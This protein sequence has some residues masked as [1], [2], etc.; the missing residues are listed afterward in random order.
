MKQQEP[1]W[2]GI[3]ISKGTLDVYLQPSRER[4]Q[5]ANQES[6]IAELVKRLQAFEFQQ[7]IVESGDESIQP[8]RLFI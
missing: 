6:G 2:V 7:V 1:Q 3:D 4:F 5:V 8:E